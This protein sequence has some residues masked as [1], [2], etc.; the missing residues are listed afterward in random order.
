MEK[1]EDY[2]LAKADHFRNVSTAVTC[3]DGYYDNCDWKII[4]NVKPT[5]TRYYNPTNKHW[6]S[7]DWIF[8]TYCKCGCGGTN[9]LCWYTKVTP[10][11]EMKY[12][13][14]DGS[15]YQIDKYYNDNCQPY[16]Q[17]TKLCYQP[18]KKPWNDFYT[19]NY[20]PCVTQI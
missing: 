10:Y 4:R 7:I 15:Y 11:S 19:A 20:E 6:Y 5:V 12:C 9:G 14:L 1:T 17:Y 8:D 3:D 2:F 16:Y 18:Q 13:P